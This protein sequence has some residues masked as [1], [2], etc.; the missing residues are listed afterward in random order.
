MLLRRVR[1]LRRPLDPRRHAINATMAPIA[2]GQILSSVEALTVGSLYRRDGLL[3]GVSARGSVPG[4]V[5]H[6]LATALD[7]PTTPKVLA[8]V[9]LAASVALLLGRNRRGLQIAASAVIGACNRLNEIRTPYGRDGADQMTAVITQY[10]TVSALVPDPE[11]ADDLFLRAVNL[12]AALSYFVSGIAKLF[13]SSW[14]QGDALGEVVQT[15]A[16][17]NGPVAGFLKA[18][19]ELAR[20]LTWA[21]PL[22][23]VSFPIIYVLPE[24]WSRVALWGVKGFHLAV[25]GVMEL[26]RFI[27]G[28]T[29]SHGA[30]QY[31]LGGHALPTSKLERVVLTSAAAVTA[32]TAT[33]ATVQRA[34]D[35]ERRRGLKGTALLTVRDGDV[36]YVHRAPGDPDIDPGTAPVVILEAGLGNPLDAW[37]WVSDS[38]RADCHLVAYHRRGYGSTTSSAE[39]LAAVDALV[40]HVGSSGPLVAVSHSI[41]VLVLAGYVGHE[42]AGRKIASVVVVDGTDPDLFA[43]DRRD[44][45]RVGSFLQSQARSMF[46]ALT[47][48]YNFTPHAVDRQSRYEPDQQSGTVQFVFG[49]RNIHR[50]TREYFELGAEGVLE[51]LREVPNRFLVASQENAA[52]QAEFARKL[53]ATHRF[54]PDSSH[55]SIIGFRQNA[56]QVAAVIEEALDAVA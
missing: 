16:Y 27:W 30:V 45:R 53:D 21:T 50:A 44:R 15:Q 29:G 1:P 7:A 19:P 55:R 3:R 18:R 51:A 9:N 24:R 20:V 28:F 25:A 14:V 42:V 6:R 23:E 34:L 38:V 10:R 22:W 33:Y 46:A 40:R 47:G 26:P 41:G 39:P 17:G 32:T 56:A 54:V 35:V 8:A 13:G 11:R 48:I 43:A 12:Q 37:A 5:R 2:V 49:P 4:T 31:V 52:Q 36:E